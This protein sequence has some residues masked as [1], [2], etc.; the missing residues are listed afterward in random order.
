MPDRYLRE[1]LLSSDRWNDLTAEAREFYIRLVLVVDDFGCY[2]GRPLV[3]NAQ[4]FPTRGSA[5]DIT[6][7]LDE[8][9]RA[10]M[11]CRYSN[12]G[13]PYI[14]L[15]RWANELLGKRR[16]PAPPINNLVADVIYRGK[17]SRPIGWRNPANCDLVSVLLDLQMRP[18]VPQPPE[19]RLVD[20]D[21]AP[22]AMV[23]R[24]YAPPGTQALHTT[25]SA[26]PDDHLV[27]RAGTPEV[28]VV[29]VDQRQKQ[30]QSP[31]SEHPATPTPGVQALP[32]TTGNGKIELQNGAWAGLSEAQR[33]KWQ[34]MFSAISIPDQLDRAA[35]WLQA[36]QDERQAIESGGKGFESFLIRWLLREVRSGTGHARAHSDA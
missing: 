31:E 9:H 14:A 5:N 26:S 8:L 3:I 23:A 17:Y 29:V 33:L 32:T 22:G 27:R 34:D 28:E 35:A 15:T 4:A 6:T 30:T 13:K 1:A 16:W 11:I 2:D 12:A 7:L 25:R 10:D 21:Y 36:H 18:T 24:P 19:W 20:R